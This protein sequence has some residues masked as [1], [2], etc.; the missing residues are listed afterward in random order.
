MGLKVL[1]VDDDPIVVFMHKRLLSKTMP[2]YEFAIA[3]NG[4]EAL[5][6]IEA[7]AD[8]NFHFLIMLDINMPEMNGYQFLDAIQ[9]L[10]IAD[11]CHVV[12]VTSSIDTFDHEKSQ[13][14]RQVLGYFEKPLRAEDCFEIMRLHTLKPF[15]EEA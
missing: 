5:K 6:Y 9:D 4:I 15:F 7:N 3:A 11:R 2:S 13:G 8:T 1:V 12:M 10:E 14:Y